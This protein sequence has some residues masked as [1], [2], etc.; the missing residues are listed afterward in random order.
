MSLFFELL[1]LYLIGNLHCVGMCGPLVFMISQHRFRYLYLLGRL[2]SFTIMG[3]VAGGLGMGLLLFLREHH[4]SAL[5]SLIMGICL[6]AGSLVLYL[7][8]K[9]LDFA[10][11]QPFNAYLT[12]R[13]LQDSPDAM[14]LFG[15]STI[16]LPCGQ[17]ILIFSAIALS[18]NEVLGAINGF[19]FA[20]LTTPSLFLA[21]HARV[22]LQRYK[23]YYR[24]IMSGLTFIIGMITC[25]RGLAEMGIMPHLSFNHFVIY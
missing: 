9:V 2:L 7:D 6:I 3:L 18:A 21:M 20:L 17:T 8:K 12:K 13:L 25:L 19:A 16:L 23:A 11:M 15:F 4:L 10:W 5:F 24:P 14:F 22:I 1:P